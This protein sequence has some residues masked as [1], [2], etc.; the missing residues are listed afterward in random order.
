MTDDTRS[1]GRD[2]YANQPTSRDF[3]ARIIMTSHFNRGA[4]WHTTRYE[5]AN[6]D[7]I[8]DNAVVWNLNGKWIASEDAQAMVAAIDRS[9]VEMIHELEQA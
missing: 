7:V 4:H 3:A 8:T 6:G 9:A 1:G 2:A 5:L